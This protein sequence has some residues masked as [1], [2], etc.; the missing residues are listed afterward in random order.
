M[1]KQARMARKAAAFQGTAA[2]YEAG[3]AKDQA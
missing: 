2:L 3:L 1:I